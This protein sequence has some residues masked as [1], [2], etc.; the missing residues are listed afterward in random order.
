MRLWEQLPGKF[1]VDIVGS[2]VRMTG[3]PEDTF[4]RSRASRSLTWSNTGTAHTRWSD[5]VADQVVATFDR[6]GTTRAPSTRFKDLVDL[7]AIVGE[8]AVEASPN[9]S[10]RVEAGRRAVILPRDF[11]VPD[12]AIWIGGYAREGGSFMLPLARTLDEALD[13]V[14]PFVD[15]ILD[16]APR[17]VEPR[18]GPLGAVGR[19]A[20]LAAPPETTDISGR[21]PRHV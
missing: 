11:S 6:Y 2:D 10:T 5:H 1:H 21:R 15:P 8:A 3:E 7:V 16:E 14:K 17:T 4:R 19:P 20:A 9:G 13:V 18:A 12:Q